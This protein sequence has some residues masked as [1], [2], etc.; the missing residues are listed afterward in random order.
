M[1]VWG[2]VHDTHIQV[3]PIWFIK[4]MDVFKLSDLKLTAA[5][6]ESIDLDQTVTVAPKKALAFAELQEL[7]KGKGVEPHRYAMAEI[8][9]LI[10][11]P[12]LTHGLPHPLLPR[13]GRQARLQAER[14]HRQAAGP[15]TAA[16]STKSSTASACVRTA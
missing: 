3:D 8:K 10:K 7:Y 12:E 11:T 14:R 1:P 6:A 9:K 4:W 16:P 13:T 15:P 2:N 5:L